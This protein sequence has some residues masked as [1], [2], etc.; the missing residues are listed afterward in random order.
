MKKDSSIPEK[1]EEYTSIENIHQF[2]TAK[3]R[4]YFNRNFFL[5]ESIDLKILVHT[6]FA[7]QVKYADKPW[8]GVYGRIK[9]I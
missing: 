6:E 2:E 1:V 4:K 7:Y 8:L 3:V 9:G 5:A